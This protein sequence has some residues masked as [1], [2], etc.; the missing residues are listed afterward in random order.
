MCPYKVKCVGEW[1][2]DIQRA[3]M[4]EKYSQLGVGDMG[5]LDMFFGAVLIGWCGPEGQEHSM[6][7]R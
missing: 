4:R 5:R 3:P 7:R 6:C 1:K 2:E